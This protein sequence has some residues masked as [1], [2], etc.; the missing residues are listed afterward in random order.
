MTALVHVYFWIFALSPLVIRGFNVDTTSPVIHSGP[1]DSLFGFS[2][3]VHQTQGTSWL[4]VG[5]PQ[6]QTDQRDVVQGGAVYKCPASP[7]SSVQCE[8]IPFGANEGDW[9][10]DR[11]GFCQAGISADIT[12]NK[13]HIVVGAIGS[14][15]NQGQVYVKGVSTKSLY[16]TR[17]GPPTD[18]NNYQ[19]CN[20]IKTMKQKAKVCLSPLIGY[21]VATGEFSNDDNDEDFVVGVPRSND[22]K[23]MVKVF[24]S[25]LLLLHELLG[26]QLGAYFGFAVAVQDVN[27]DRIDD[28]IVGAPF[29]TDKAGTAEKWEAGRVY[30]YLQN[31]NNDFSDPSM[32]TGVQSRARFGSSLGT[33]HDINQDGFKDIA[34]GAP[35][36]GDDERGAVYIYHG[37]SKGLK[38][39]PAQIIKASDISSN[40]RTFGSSLSGG[41]DM[42]KNHYTD[43]LVGAYES[44]QVIL[45]RSKPVVNLDVNIR[46][47]TDFIDL[48]DKK[49]ADHGIPVACFTLTTCFSYT[50]RHV[51]SSI[52]V[53]F[54]ISLDTLKFHP[55]RAYFRETG[56]QD[57]MITLTI[58][59][60]K[61]EL[62]KGN[63]VFLKSDIKDKYSAIA[64][65]VSYKL[66]EN[67]DLVSMSELPPVVNK[68]LTSV[69]RK[70]AHILNDCGDS[71]ICVP[72]LSLKAEMS[73]PIYIGSHDLV[74]L[75]VTVTNNGDDAFESQVTIQ[76]PP[77]FHYVRVQ[78]RDSDYTVGCMDIDN[79]IGL[80][81]CD[82]GNPISAGHKV[83]FDLTLSTI[84]Y[85]ITYSTEE[86][87]LSANSSNAEESS[88]LGDNN[89]IVI[90]PVKINAGI[91]FTGK[92]V[93]KTV[94]QGQ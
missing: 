17:E 23:G 67:E 32:L 86:I 66:V 4:L 14:Y 27:N 45:L 36:G 47:S 46:F 38:K 74:I 53:E 58:H 21:S 56:A 20:V 1:T 78:K 85:N 34:I 69:I 89:I 84:Q 65:D 93:Q 92:S 91:S 81:I 51:P 80:V 71:K 59:K 22:L 10:W 61:R 31:H 8:Q 57:E 49:C 83:K 90:I 29:F 87:S 52:E 24:N 54:I 28:I 3:S 18:D 63:F 73:S 50:G 42:D 30:V 55:K 72:D 88:T 75:E 77:G 41:L 25:Q 94:L 15:Y 79:G 60:K 13:K 37:S 33:L 12:H 44:D 68:Q 82:C 48:E 76:L 40:L 9:G 19:A 70:Q 26:E 5:A 43:L 11:V 62:C 64:V 2:V 35:Y 6:A 16:S 39:N 7:D